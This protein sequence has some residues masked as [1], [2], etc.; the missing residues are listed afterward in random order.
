MNDAHVYVL[1]HKSMYVR[2]VSQVNDENKTPL[3]HLI[4]D[5]DNQQVPYLELEFEFAMDLHPFYPPLVKV[6]R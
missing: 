3:T 4:L 5:P 2:R 1:Y 6:I